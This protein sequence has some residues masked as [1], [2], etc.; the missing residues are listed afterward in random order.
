MSGVEIERRLQEALV[1][2]P[3]AAG[4]NNHQGSRASADPRL[5]ALLM[6]ALKGRDM[7]FL[8]SRT[9]SKSVGQAAAAKAGVDFAQRHVFL[10]N[11]EQT[12]AIARQWEKVLRR[13]EKKGECVAIGHPYPVTL[14]FLYSALD[15][16]KARGMDL[17]RVSDLLEREL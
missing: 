16:V 2:L 9:T 5:M 6:S 10:D 4:L 8:D 1:S 15:S 12:D 7:Y 3:Q 14:E 13:A 11:Q 17:V